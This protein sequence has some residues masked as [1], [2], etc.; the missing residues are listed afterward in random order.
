MAGRWMCYG[1]DSRPTWPAQ[2][3]VG[4][5]GQDTGGER[6]H[7][8]KEEEEEGKEERNADCRRIISML[9]PQDLYYLQCSDTNQRRRT[10]DLSVC[11]TRAQE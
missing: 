9:T 6:T 4:G 11:S 8:C 7:E 1:R 2:E 5:R 10:P 3:Q